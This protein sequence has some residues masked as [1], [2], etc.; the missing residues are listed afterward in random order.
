[1]GKKSRNKGKRGEREFA[2]KSDGIRTWWTAGP[3][4]PEDAH[5]VYAHDRPWEVKL[6]AN[7]LTQAYKALEEFEEHESGAHRPIV[8]ARMDNKPWIVIQYY[9]CWKE[10]HVGTP[11]EHDHRS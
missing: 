1:M 5:D 4:H 9:C 6:L 8:A 3:E 2:T 7:G 11:Q 10:D